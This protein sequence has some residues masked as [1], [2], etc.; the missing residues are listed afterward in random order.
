STAVVTLYS[1]STVH[2]LSGTYGATAFR[3]TNARFAPASI[4]S[5]ARN[6]AIWRAEK[7]PVPSLTAT[8]VRPSPSS[9]VPSSHVTL[10]PLTSST[11]QPHVPQSA[12]LIPVSP[13]SVPLNQRFCHSWP[14][15]VWL[16]TPCG[17]PFIACMPTKSAASQP[18]SRNA[19]YSVHS[20]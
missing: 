13:T 8:V 3:S 12:A 11:G 10:S 17:A 16:S 18:D 7:R 9:A 14:D 1:T 4:S 19:V 6:G 20:C 15:T 5:R 2:G